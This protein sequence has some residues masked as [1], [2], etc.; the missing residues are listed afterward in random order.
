MLISRQGLP[1]HKATWENCADFAQQFP[2]LHLEDKVS[3]ERGS[4][5]KPPIIL[6]YS[7][8]KKG[9]VTRAKEKGNGGGSGNHLGRDHG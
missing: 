6:Q 8:R 7:R 1:P 3:L 4:C 9:E 2:H 5:D